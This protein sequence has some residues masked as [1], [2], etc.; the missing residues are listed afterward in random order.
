MSELRSD[1]NQLLMKVM[2]S[3]QALWWLVDNTEDSNAHIGYCSI[4]TEWFQTNL[5]T[6]IVSIV[7][8]GAW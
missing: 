7:V 1:I 4:Q 5:L 8:A 2:Y 3:F 6:L